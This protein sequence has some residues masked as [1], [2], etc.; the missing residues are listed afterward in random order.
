MHVQADEPDMRI[1]DQALRHIQDGLNVEPEL[2]SLDTG[3]GLDVR[4]GW[5]V[6]VHAQ[7]DG[8]P[9]SNRACYFLK[10]LQLRIALNIE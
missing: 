10:G 9:M 2:D 3:V 4:L 7:G 5:K 8:S 6:R 1:A